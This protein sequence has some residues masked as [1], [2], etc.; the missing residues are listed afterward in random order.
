M[1]ACGLLGTGIWGAAASL[2]G[3]EPATDTATPLVQGFRRPPD[4]TKPWVY[5]YWITDNIS[6]EGITRDLEAMARAGIGE[7][8]IGNIFLEDVQRG[9]VKALTDPWWGMVEHAIREGGRVGVNIGMFN[10]PGWSQSGGP[11][12]K[13]EQAMRY[14]VSAERRVTG[15][16][17]FEQRLSVPKEPFQDVAVLAFPAPSSDADTAAGRSPKV[18]CTPAVE[19]APQLCDGNLKTVCPIGPSANQGRGSLAIDIDLA[20]ALTARSLVLHPASAALAAQ[21]ELLAADDAG[22]FQCIR[23]FTL[24][25][26]NVEIHVGPMPYGPVVVSFPPV[27]SKRFRLRLTNVRGQGGLAEIELSGAAR[28]ERFVEKQLGK[29]H[30]TPLPMWDT[31]LWPQQAEPD[32]PQLA[33]PPGEVVD[34]SDRLAAD[35]TLRWD[36]PPGEWVILRTGMTP[37]GTKNAPASPEGQGLEVDKMNRQAAEAHFDAFIGQLLKRMPA[38]ERTAFKHVV[39]DS[40]EMGS[41]NWTDRFGEVFRERYGYDAR[42]WLP[43][44]TGRIVGTADQSNRFLWDLRRLVADRVAMDYV[45]GLREVCHRHGLKLWLENYGHWGFPAEFLQYG[46][47]ADHISGEFWATG[48][49]GSIELRAASSASHIYGMPIT[50]AEAFTGGPFFVSTPWALKRRGDWAA[51]EGINHFVLHVYIHQPSDERR[52]GVNAWFGTEFNRHNTWFESSGTWIEYL[53]RSHFLL[54]Q[55]QNLADVAYFIGED[56]PKMTGVRQPSLPA[57][58]DFDYINAEVI[59]QSLGVEDGRFVLPDGTSY[60]LLVL[61]ELDTMRPELLRKIRDLVAAGGAVLGPPPARSPSLQDYPACDEQVQKLAGEVWSNCDGQTVQQVRFGQ[62][63]VFRNMELAAV[64]ADLKT[65]PDV[66]G[67]DAKKILWTHRRASGTDL[68]F[69]SSQSDHPVSIAPVFRVAGQAPELWHADSGRIVRAAVF[70]AADGGVRVPLELGARGSV[71][72]VFREPAGTAP[73]VTEV[74]RDG[75]VVLSTAAKA[76]EPQ[77][78][79]VK[80]GANTF[81]LAGWLKPNADIALPQEADSGVFLQ[82]A[83]N[84]AIFPAHGASLFGGDQ[85]AGAGIS[86]GRNGVAVYEHS[87]SY[88]APL[89]VHAAPLADWTHVAVVYQAG[90]PS[91]Y[92]NGKLAHQGLQSRYTVHP[93]PGGQGGPGGPFQGEMGEIQPLSRAPAAAEIA[94]LAASPPPVAGDLPLPEVTLTR[95]AEGSL[96]AEVSAAG[97]Y[98]VKLADGQIR[99][100]AVPAPPKPLEIRGPWQV[101]FPPGMDVPPRTEFE[102]LMSWTEHPQP[103]IQYFS[104]TATYSRSLDLPADRL[105]ES[106]SALLD[107]GRVESLA[108][109]VVN[110]RKLGVLWKP[111]FVVDITA[112]ARPGENTLEIRVTNAWLNR[113]LGDKQHPQGFPDA[114]PLQFKPQLAADISNRLGP[115]PAPAGLLGPV[116]L[117]T[118]ERVRIP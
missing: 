83:R 68:Y 27:Q 84:D 105:S 52:P 63:R 45:G 43:V 73:S 33:V 91:L 50:S 16:A 17:Q 106:R 62:G 53:R 69:L 92:L 61:P 118:T 3:S 102:R 74:T 86:V 56:T 88:F 94:E 47:Q 103:A 108:E 77:T 116:R 110:G 41:Q 35:G 113:L 15:P 19:S 66:S 10:C 71:F 28:L 40:Y 78:A 48:E 114:G 18:T 65:P 89:L 20:E 80:D 49:L 36:V 29:M 22:A 25:R 79:A 34:L 98:R 112:A 60:R 111:P 87:S 21:C 90:R 117:L 64:L 96:Q 104:G 39:A 4:E 9:S 55:G 67:V 30:P 1:V 72:V 57:G 13:P 23:S 109:V 101:S 51:T 11:W 7:A 76:V 59:E 54:Q 24:D 85:H 14:L 31:Y 81:T 70:E 26:S 44:L 37:T 99:T 107:L 42:R 6:R 32:A 97:S 5:W 46:G 8:L 115:Q 75:R 95:T 38:S 2:L 93:S 82:L 12:I 100:F 58:Y